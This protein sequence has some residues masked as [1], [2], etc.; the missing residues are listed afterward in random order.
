MPIKFRPLRTPLLY[1]QRV[2]AGVYIIS[3][4]YGFLVFCMKLS[5]ES[6]IWSKYCIK[7]ILIEKCTKYSSV[8]IVWDGE[9]ASVNK[10]FNIGVLP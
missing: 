2:F 7:F 8:L 1:S 3:A 9:D 4:I 5:F 6:D 10:N